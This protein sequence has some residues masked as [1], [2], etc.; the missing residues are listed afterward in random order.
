MAKAKK[1]EIIEED[2]NN[3]E[4]ISQEESEIDGPK[5]VDESFD[6]QMGEIDQAE[7]ETDTVE[8]IA[9]EVEAINTDNDTAESM[10][11]KAEKSEDAS[12][13]KKTTKKKASKIIKKKAKKK[14]RS[15]NY[16][17]SAE[18]VDKNKKYALE[19]A[20]ELIK[21]L[22]YSKF[23]GTISMA[24]KLEKAKKN[25]KIDQKDEKK[26]ILVDSVKKIDFDR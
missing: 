5:T 21:K 20:I 11:I 17:K 22:S 14:I 23:D 13:E 3:Q 6:A 16:Q 1:E 15:K 18:E 4:I 2:L 8:E 26:T 19:D 10:N 12:K 24:V 7:E 25:G 9:P